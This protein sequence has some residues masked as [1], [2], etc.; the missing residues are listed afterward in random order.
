VNHSFWQQLFGAKLRGLKWANEFTLKELK[1]L[2]YLII[3]ILFGNISN[4][5]QYPQNNH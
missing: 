2:K 3:L 1:E 4:K 5:I